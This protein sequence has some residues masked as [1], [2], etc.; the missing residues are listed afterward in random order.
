M[1]AVDAKEFLSLLF[2][3]ESLNGLHLA[4]WD[5]K[6]HHTHTF[7]LPDLDGAAGDAVSRAV[8]SD[9]YFGVCPYVKV[10]LGSRGVADN[11]GAMVGLWLDVDVKN[12]RAHTATA[13]PETDEQ[14]FDLIYEMPKKPSIVVH[15]GYGLQAWWLF[16]EPVMLRTQADRIAAGMTAASWVAVGNKIAAKRGWKLDTV[17]DLARVLRVPGTLNHKGESP[18]PVEIVSKG[19]RG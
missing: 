17:G 13:L 18:R 19:A 12:G 6:E 14:A 3:H 5:L 1:A 16:E 8:A 10:D 9:V 7:R 15:S 2:G 11:A 4:I